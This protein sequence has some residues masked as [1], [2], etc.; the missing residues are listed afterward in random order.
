VSFE[1][2]SSRCRWTTSQ[3]SPGQLPAIDLSTTC[4]D[5]SVAGAVMPLIR[6]ASLTA[7]SPLAMPMLKGT[8]SRS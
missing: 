4:S 8:E 3:A 7:R 5:L 6:T 1:A 2:A